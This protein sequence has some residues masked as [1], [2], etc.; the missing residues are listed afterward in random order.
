MAQSRRGHGRQRWAAERAHFDVVLR[1]LILELPA[2][3]LRIHQTTMLRVNPSVDFE[4]EAFLRKPVHRY[5]VIHGTL[6]D[7]RPWLEALQ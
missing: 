1:K 7:R 6:P 4:H 2:G 5:G 3:P